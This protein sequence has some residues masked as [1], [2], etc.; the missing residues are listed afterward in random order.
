MQ[1]QS[2]T[3]KC[4]S[5]F[6]KEPNEKEV[7][8]AVSNGTIISNMEMS[9][10]LEYIAKTRMLLGMPK[11][12]NNKEE[13]VIATQFV[14]NN[15]GRLTTKEYELAFNLFIMQKYDTDVQFYGMLSPLFISQ[16]LNEY[17]NYKKSKI[18]DAIIGRDKAI[19]EE[20]EKSKE[21]TKEQKAENQK[22]IIKEFWDDWKQKGEFNDYTS[23]SYKFFDKNKDLFKFNFDAKKVI[24]A[25]DWANKKMIEDRSK[26]GLFR[27]NDKDE[28]LQKK[29]YCRIWCVMDYFSRFENVDEI[30]NLIT[31]DLW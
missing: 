28:I 13:L 22:V 5:E 24:D 20:E 4:L 17:L 12:Y 29:K 26:G 25:Q 30:L 7:A 15:Y 27:Y 9:S 8:I 31:P 11:D 16:V 2:Q 23:L 1:V 6:T 10:L 3:Q 21:P 19:L 14:H 18:A